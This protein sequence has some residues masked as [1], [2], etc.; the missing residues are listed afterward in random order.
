M[1]WVA[2]AHDLVRVQGRENRAA[3]IDTLDVTV[4]A[5]ATAA[6]TAATT[7]TTTA[8]RAIA[9]PANVMAASA[10]VIFVRTEGP[11]GFGV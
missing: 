1:S 3:M 9:P 6:T 2:L 10:T 8:T 11:R 4:T 7:A 5:T